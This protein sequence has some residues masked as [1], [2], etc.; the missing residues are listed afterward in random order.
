MEITTA[1][2]NPI[3]P[4][5]FTLEETARLLGISHIHTANLARAGKLPGAFRLGTRWV[6]SRQ[7]IDRLLADP[8][9]TA[10]PSVG[11]VAA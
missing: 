2:T 11:G 10:V 7:V 3:V 5:T 4:A 6:V 1:I 8:S 9:S